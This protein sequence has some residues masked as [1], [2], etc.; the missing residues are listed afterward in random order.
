M[1]FVAIGALRVNKYYTLQRVNN[2][3]TEQTVRM[4]RLVCAFAGH[5][6][7]NQIFLCWGLNDGVDRM[8]CA[9]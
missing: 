2:K 9:P 3:E 8:G 5:M 7:Q 4:R 1:T 6:Q